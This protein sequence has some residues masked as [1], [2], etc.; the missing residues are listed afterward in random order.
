MVTSHLLADYSPGTFTKA[1]ITISHSESFAVSMTLPI[2]F[3][4]FLAKSSNTPRYYMKIIE[5][6]DGP[7]AIGSFAIPFA[8]DRPLTLMKSVLEV[9]EGLL[10]RDTNNFDRLRSFEWPK[11]SLDLHLVIRPV[12]VRYA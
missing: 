5:G 11:F 4:T 7:P 6:D 8:L 9:V 2:L 1:T 12:L 10:V 3:P